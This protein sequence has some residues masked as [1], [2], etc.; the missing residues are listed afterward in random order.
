ML[1]HWSGPL[2][3]KRTAGPGKRQAQENMKVGANQG[4]GG[5]GSAQS[6]KGGMDREMVTLGGSGDMELGSLVW[7]HRGFACPGFCEPLGVLPAHQ[8]QG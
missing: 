7:L 4:G 5:V 8:L 1:K 2:G 3:G 6:F